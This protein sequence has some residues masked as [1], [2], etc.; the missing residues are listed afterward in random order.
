[1]LSCLF[2][3]FVKPA[4]SIENVT[5]ALDF[6]LALFES[7]VQIWI[8]KLGVISQNR[9]LFFRWRGSRVA[10]GIRL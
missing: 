10:K 6:S 8:D 5:H 1:M 9:L 2:D 7:N 3:F 4:G